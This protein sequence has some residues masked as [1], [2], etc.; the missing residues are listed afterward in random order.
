MPQRTGGG[1]GKC[2]ADRWGEVAAGWSCLEHL[3][4]MW[5]PHPARMWM[6]ALDIRGYDA[7]SCKCC[8]LDV[9]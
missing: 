9:S 2:K 6:D 7:L 5:I 4:Q 1:G 8:T 3:V